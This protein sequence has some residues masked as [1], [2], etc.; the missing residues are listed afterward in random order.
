M[1]R[2]VDKAGPSVL[3]P[4]LVSLLSL[5]SLSLPLSPSLP[6]SFSRVCLCAGL[7]EPSVLPPSRLSL[8]RSDSLSPSLSFLSLCLPLC[9]PLAF[10]LSVSAPA[11]SL[12]PYASL[13]LCVPVSVSPLLHR[14]ASLFSLSEMRTMLVSVHSRS[15][16][17]MQKA[18]RCRSRRGGLPRSASSSS[19]KNAPRALTKD[20]PGS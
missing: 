17:P 9:L 2:S 18:R 4:L 11:L 7:V 14:S 6:R 10:S 15:F 1:R 12:S 13:Y 20:R 16:L 19:T 8:A 5:S 3:L